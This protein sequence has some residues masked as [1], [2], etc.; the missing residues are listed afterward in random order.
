MTFK[1]FTLVSCF[2]VTSLPLSGSEIETSKIYKC[3]QFDDYLT[4]KSVGFEHVNHIVYLNNTEVT[5][6]SQAM[7]FVDSLTCSSSGFEIKVNHAQY[8]DFESK[9]YSLKIISSNKYKL[10]EN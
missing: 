10:K 7:W 4:I 6:L 3:S 9:L 1:L 5:E 2:I 8:G